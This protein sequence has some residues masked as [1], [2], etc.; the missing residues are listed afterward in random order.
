MVPYM[1]KLSIKY[2][3]RNFPF[4]KYKVL[5]FPFVSICVHFSESEIIPINKG[6][7]KGKK[8]KGVGNSGL[9]LRRVKINPKRL[10]MKVRMQPI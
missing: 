7:H 1:A 5:K 2:K 9:I 6:N 3:G 4:E 8:D 10:D